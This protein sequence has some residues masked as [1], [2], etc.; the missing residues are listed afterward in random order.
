LCELRQDGFHVE[1][2]LW[3]LYQLAHGATILKMNSRG[4]RMNERNLLELEENLGKRE[5]GLKRNNNFRSNDIALQ[6]FRCLPSS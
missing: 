5:R 6:L 2:H 1:A 4:L 3:L